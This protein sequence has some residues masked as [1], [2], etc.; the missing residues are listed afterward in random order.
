V[1]TLIPSCKCAINPITNP[2]PVLTR[3]NN[4]N[5]NNGN[6]SN[7]SNNNNNNYNSLINEDKRIYMHI[8]STD[9]GDEKCIKHIY[10]EF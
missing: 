4:N 9:R 10:L 3:D 2:N 7:N 6:N 8:Y 5:N 1:Y